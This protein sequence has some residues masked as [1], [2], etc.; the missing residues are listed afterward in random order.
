[1]GTRE[2]RLRVHV[3]HDTMRVVGIP[4]FMNQG[5]V[6]FRHLFTPAQFDYFKRY[7]TGLILAQGRRTVLSISRLYLDACDQSRL[8]RFLNDPAWS[9]RAVADLRRRV[10]RGMADRTGAREHTV[11]LDDT[12]LN[13]ADG[14]CVEGSARHYAGGYHGVV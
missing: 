14:Y 8:S 2:N 3:R 10:A 1:M 12:L 4:G 5:L 13:R 6:C 11:I 9:R 7:V